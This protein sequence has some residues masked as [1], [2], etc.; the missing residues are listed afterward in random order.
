MSGLKGGNNEDRFKLTGKVKS[1]DEDLFFHLFLEFSSGDPK[2]GAGGVA[3][4]HHF[5]A[6][7]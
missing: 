2:G 1:R 7:L 5:Q 4:S 6:Y 3:R